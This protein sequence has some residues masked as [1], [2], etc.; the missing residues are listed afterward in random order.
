[1]SHVSTFLSCQLPYP[2]HA[3]R[4][5]GSREDSYL[6]TSKRASGNRTTAKKET[7]INNGQSQ[8]SLLLVEVLLWCP[9]SRA[10]SETGSWT[11]LACAGG[12]CWSGDLADSSMLPMRRFSARSRRS[13]LY[14]CRCYVGP[15]GCRRLSWK[16]VSLDS[17]F[18]RGRWNSLRLVSSRR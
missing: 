17:G 2:T 14:W 6:N 12:D 16:S 1:M 13:F 7:K 3:G 9:F 5:A 15:G 8:F 4:P 11:A 18:P 10:A